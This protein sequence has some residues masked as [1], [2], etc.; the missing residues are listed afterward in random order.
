MKKASTTLI[1]KQQSRILTAARKC[2]SR[3]GISRTTMRDIAS[4]ADISLGNIYRYF[5]NK[6]AMIHAFI[7]RDNQEIDEA[8]ALLDGTKHFKTLLR[9]IVKEIITELATKSELYIYLDMLILGLQDKDILALVEL[10]KSEQ[11]LEN[12]LQKAQQESLITLALSPELTALA[13]MAFIEK[14]AIKCVS[15]PKYTR[16][17]A[18]KQFKQYINLLI[19]SS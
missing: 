7:E 17:K 18:N 9:H 5:E 13:I 6:N 19:P 15:D 10:E 8:F 11:L 4:E 3:N 12:S 2:F 14:A 16:K 1:S